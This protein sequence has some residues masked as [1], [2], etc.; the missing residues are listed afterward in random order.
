MLN[1]LIYSV[2]ISLFLSMILGT[3]IN[4]F[5]IG[6][7]LRILLPNCALAFITI[8]EEP[9]SFSQYCGTGETPSIISVAQEND[10]LTGQGQHCKVY[11]AEI[12][13]DMTAKN[14]GF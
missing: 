4:S 1:Y 7:K 5:Q 11:D 9:L 14:L 10:S 3:V 12:L 6:T 13:S 8:H 2:K